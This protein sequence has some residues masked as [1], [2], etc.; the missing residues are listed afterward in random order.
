MNILL[1]IIIPCYKAENV[2]ERCV[3]SILRQTFKDFELILVEDGSVDG[4]GRIAEEIAKQDNRLLVI[5]QQNAGAMK[6]R[7]TGVKVAN[8]EWVTFVD[9]DDTLP[10]NALQDLYQAIQGNVSTEMVI[11]FRNG[12]KIAKVGKEYSLVDYRYDVI[13]RNRFHV[14]PWGRLYRRELFTDFMFDIPRSVL[15]GEDWLFNI[16]YAFAMQHKPVVVESC[17]YNYIITDGGLHTSEETPESLIVYDC[18]RLASVPTEYQEQYM[19]AIMEARVIPLLEWTF[20][21]LF[22]ISWQNN[23]YVTYL[24]SEIKKVDYSLTFQQKMLLSPN[25]FLRFIYFNFLR[26]TYH[27]Q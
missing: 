17:V 11:G 2:L 13:S 14:A 4:T 26:L 22:C 8:G 27:F 6:A 5:H 21:N 24:K 9:C 3:E 12:V 1:S 23:A 7:H 20:A 15:K 16:R 18:L 19:S 25:I 10:A